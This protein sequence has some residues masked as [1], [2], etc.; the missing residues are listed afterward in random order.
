M[1]N[2]DEFL[3]QLNA[4]REE[5]KKEIKD[6]E[7]VVGIKQIT[8]DLSVALS[9]TIEEFI[10]SKPELRSNGILAAC[11]AHRSLFLLA[12]CAS[13]EWVIDAVA[14]RKILMAKYSR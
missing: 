2:E 1:K 9:N 7:K 11:V 5:M 13:Y 8:D 10:L 3:K 4:F 12:N 6:T 14:S